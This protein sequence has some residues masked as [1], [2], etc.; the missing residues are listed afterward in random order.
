MKKYSIMILISAMTGFAASGQV[1]SL[2]LAF[3]LE[4][5]ARNNPAVKAA[6]NT[7]EAALQKIPQAGAYEDPQLEMGFFLRPMDI[8]D[9]RQV[10]QF[11]LM[12]MFPWFGTKKAAR[13]EAMHMAKMAFEQ[14]RETRDNIFLEVYTQWYIL[15]GLQQKLMTGRENIALLE[16]L[17]SL[18]LQRFKSPVNDSE[19]A[20]SQK[21]DNSASTSAGSRSGGMSGMNMSGKSVAGES[22]NS[23]SERAGGS[24][25]GNSMSMGGAS[26]GMSEVLN[27][28]LETAELESSIESIL[29]EIRVEKVRFNALLNRP[30]ETEISVPDSIVR[31]SF[32]MDEES[33]MN[34]I[35]QQNPMLGMI[36]EES[37][38]YDAKAEMD[39]KMGY[40]MFGI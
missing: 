28:R 6:F 2:E 24:M 10:G 37:R 36:S 22:A 1:D 17:E 16:N 3:Y 13:T 38:A 32:S 20:V 34:L 14:F 27:I 23:S 26:S 15:C 9:G 33:V 30:V 35:A 11:Q 39:R 7:Y 8:V 21:S 29:S 40:P 4:T 31:L 19:A 5:A 12:Q 18:A 25:S